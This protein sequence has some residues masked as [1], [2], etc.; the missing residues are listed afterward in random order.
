MRTQ[1]FG[2]RGRESERDENTELWR[3]RERERERERSSQTGYN[4]QI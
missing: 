2:E 1:N 3:E 4:H